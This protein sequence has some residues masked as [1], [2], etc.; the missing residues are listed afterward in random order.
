[1]VTRMSDDTAVIYA[2]VS[3]VGDRRC[4]EAEWQGSEHCAEGEEGV[5]GHLLYCALLISL[6]ILPILN[7]R[8]KVNIFCLFYTFVGIFTLYKQFE[9]YISCITQYSV[10]YKT[11]SNGKQRC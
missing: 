8:E 4:G 6:P 7:Y 9:M 11:R 1:M 5:C 10:S 2:R 3:S